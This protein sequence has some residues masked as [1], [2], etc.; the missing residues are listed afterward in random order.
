MSGV[1]VG[2]GKD[3]SRNKRRKL[4]SQ[5]ERGTN[6]KNDQMGDGVVTRSDLGKTRGME[7]RCPLTLYDGF[8][9]EVLQ[10]PSPFFFRK[11]L[12]GFSVV[13]FFEADDKVK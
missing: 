9:C 8:R 5:L 3:I 12:L 6:E 10:F 11:V 1:E 13:R 2:H 7:L 4:F